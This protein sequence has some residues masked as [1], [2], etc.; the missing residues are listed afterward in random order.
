MRQTDEKINSFGLS[1]MVIAL[2]SSPFYGAFSAYIINY[3]KTASLISI[4]IGFLISLVLSSIILLTFKSHKELNLASS[5]KKDFKVFSYVINILFLIGAILMYIFLTYR[6]TLFLSN[7]YLIQTPNFVILLIILIVTFNTASKGIETTIRVSTISLFISLFIFLF[8]FF[9]LIPQVNIENFLPIITV[10]SKNILISSLVYAVY[11]S[12]PLIFLQAIKYNQIVDSNKF[13]K[14]YY[15]MIILSFITSF[16]SMFTTI[17]VSGVNIN[18]LFDYP[19]YS[20]L[21]RINLFNFLDSIENISIMLWILYIINSANMILLFI[22]NNM[23]STFNLDKK[24]SRIFNIII[25]LVIFL[26][27]TLLFSKNDFVESYKYIWYPFSTLS[28]LFI[29]TII[30]LVFNKIKNKFKKSN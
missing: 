3:S 12:L 19:I 28:I 24:K 4:L 30:V 20:T 7:E 5:I 11:F 6:L 27:P 2:T 26:I 29:L 17:G 18:N 1:T 14:H 8:D 16:L 13:T 9:S 10:S 21:K 23:K 25:M 22:F 15:L